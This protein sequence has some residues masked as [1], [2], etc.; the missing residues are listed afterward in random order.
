[1]AETRTF[2]ELRR[3]ARAAGPAAVALVGADSESGLRALALA[4]GE[5]LARAALVGD[6]AAARGLLDRAGIAGLDQARYVPAGS[7]AEAAAAAVALARAGEASVLLKGSLR[8]DQLMRAVLDRDRGLRTGG[9]LS[10]VLLYEDGVS[11]ARRLVGITDGGINPAPDVEALKQIVANAV[12]VFRALGYR[13]PRV[14]LLSATEAVSDAVPSTVLARAV[15]DWAARAMDDADVDGPLALDNALLP[16]AAEA[17]GIGG[18][19]AGRAD[20][21]V[22][23]S[24]D[25]GNILGKAAKYLAGSITAHVVVGARVPILIPS[26]V[27]SAEDKLHSVALGVLVGQARTEVTE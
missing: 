16:A 21:M 26:R 6:E 10:D 3:R 24:I 15:A 17:K 2:D 1:V 12:A 14:A 19:V 20:I 27:E 25:A 11:G 4:A 9:L 7:P 13:R 5:G 18:P 23:P 22:A 8:T